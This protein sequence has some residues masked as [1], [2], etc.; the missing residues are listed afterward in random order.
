MASSAAPR[1]HLAA[2]FR[3]DEV[4]AGGPAEEVGHVAA[5]AERVRGRVLQQ[6]ERVVE[7]RLRKRRICRA[8][9]LCCSLGVQRALPA[10]GTHVRD[11]L[12]VVVVQNHHA[13]RGA[14]R[15]RL[16][17]E[18]AAQEQERRRHDSRPAYYSWSPTRRS[19]S[20]Q[21]RHE[22]SAMAPSLASGLCSNGACRGTHPAWFAP[23][24][25]NGQR[26]TG[27]RVYNSLTG[28]KELFVPREGNRVT[29]YTCGPTVY[30]VCHMGHARAY[31]TMDIIRRIL[32]DYLGYEVFLQVCVARAPQLLHSI[33][34][35][36]AP[37]SVNP[38]YREPR[39][40]TLALCHAC[41]CTVGAGA[42]AA[43]VASDACF[44]AWTTRY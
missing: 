35:L 3:A 20:W 30:D 12:G 9:E 36:H 21:H 7:R 34:W 17:G 32:E 19:Y 11:A 40:C 23:D 29:W 37:A 4:K 24:Q 44:P 22:H 8:P 14:S 10:Q 18:A 15:E 43:P 1:S 16:P 5:R 26:V 31:L 42:L 13:R 27:L 28:E 38:R 39:R 6:D 2:A 33:R 25:G 41:P